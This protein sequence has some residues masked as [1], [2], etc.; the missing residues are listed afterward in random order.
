MTNNQNKPEWKRD[1]RGKFV[2]GHGPVADPAN[3]V[4]E[5]DCWIEAGT[6]EMEGFISSLLLEVID[7][8]ELEKKILD[9]ESSENCWV[10]LGGTGYNKAVSDLNKIKKSIKQKYGIE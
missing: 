1:F 9:V 7:E 8:I 4:Q 3:D 2:R 6:K 10:C 5:A